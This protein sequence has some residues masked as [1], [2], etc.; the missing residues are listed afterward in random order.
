M[1]T[2]PYPV[3]GYNLPAK[4]S[5]GSS[6]EAFVIVWSP[7]SSVAQLTKDSSL[8]MSGAFDSFSAKKNQK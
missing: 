2:C 6:V 3:K 8:V 4:D 1:L 7:S 5:N